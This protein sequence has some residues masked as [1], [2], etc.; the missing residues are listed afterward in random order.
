MGIIYKITNLLNGKIYIG[1]T[2][3]PLKQRM[4]KHYSQANSEGATGIDGAIRKYGKDN[5]QIEIICECPEGE[6]DTK[7]Q[8]YIALYN[9]YEGGYNLSIGGQHNTTYLNLDEDS[10]IKKFHELQNIKKTATYFKCCDKVI[11][12]ILIKNG[13]DTLQYNR[14]QALQNLQKGTN[15]VKH[16]VYIVDLDKTFESL[17]ECGR[18]LRQNNYSK[19]GTDEQAAKSIGRVA[20]GERQTY[21]NLHFSYVEDC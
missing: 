4:Y 10:V 19:A 6:L 3:T 20:R 13:V 7:E 21:C 12:N 5:F 9:S 2:R 18:W 11:S 8:E 15:K 17:I 1:Q 16:G 14:K